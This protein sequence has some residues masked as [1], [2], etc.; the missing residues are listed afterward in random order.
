MKIG[1]A[2]NT[3]IHF[4]RKLFMLGKLILIQMFCLLKL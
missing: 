1:V 3:R 4:R 2:T